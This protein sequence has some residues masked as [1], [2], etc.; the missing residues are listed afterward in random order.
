VGLED[1]ASLDEKSAIVQGLAS[2][3]VV[4]LEDA[5][6]KERNVE[7]FRLQEEC[8]QAPAGVKHKGPIFQQIKRGITREAQFGKDS[9]RGAFSLRLAGSVDD[10]FP[11]AVKITDGRIDLMKSD[12]Q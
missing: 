10:A 3:G 11:V 4:P 8:F 5:P 2:A 6:H 7:F 9:E 1:A 12:D